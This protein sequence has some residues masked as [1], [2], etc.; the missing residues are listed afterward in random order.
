M[1]EGSGDVVAGIALA[2]FGQGQAVLEQ[3]HTGV[4]QI[5]DG[6]NVLGVPE[7]QDDIGKFE[8]ALF[9]GLGNAHHVADDLKRQGSSDIAD[10]VALAAFGDGVHDGGGSRPHGVVESGNPFGRESSRDQAADLGVSRGVHVDDGSQE[11]RQ[12]VGD[13][14]NVGAAASRCEQLGVTAHVGDVGMAGHRPPLKVTGAGQK[15]YSPLRRH[16]QFLAQAGKQQVPVGPE[17]RGPLTQVDVVDV[18][19]IGRAPAQAVDAIAQSQQFVGGVGGSVGVGDGALGR[20]LPMH[21][22]N[23]SARCPPGHRIVPAGFLDVVVAHGRASWSS[24][25]I[26]AQNPAGAA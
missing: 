7:P 20:Q 12:F 14:A 16:R 5:T 11:L 1:H 13:I 19:L 24:L 25:T 10:H 2:G 15:R 9:V 21:V 6:G 17:P 8:H 22:A 23:A 18:H 3:F 26:G 4:D